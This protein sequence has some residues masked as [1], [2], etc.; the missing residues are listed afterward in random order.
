MKLLSS[1]ER[2]GTGSPS[3]SSMGVPL[4]PNPLNRSSVRQF[5]SVVG[6]FVTDWDPATEFGSVARTVSAPTTKDITTINFSDFIY[7]PPKG[8]VMR[9]PIGKGLFL[10]AILIRRNITYT[11]LEHDDPVSLSV[12]RTRINQA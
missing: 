8:W 3:H 6:A 1:N 7:F 9:G 4:A 10:E 12:G 11:G 2:P 5:R